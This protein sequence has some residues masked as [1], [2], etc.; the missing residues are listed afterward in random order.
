V[1]R[2]ITSWFIVC[3]SAFLLAS[4]VVG[5]LLLSLYRQST[6]EQ[7][8]RASA[9]VAHG[10]DAIAGRY[11][12]FLAGATRPPSDI[13]AAQFAQGLTSAVQIALRD[14]PGVEGGVWQAEQGSLA[15]AFPTYEGTGEKTDLPAAEEPHGGRQVRVDVRVLAATNRDLETAARD[16]RFRED[17]FYR[18]NVVPIHLP[19]L[20]ERLEDIVPLA[21]YFLRRATDPPKQLGAD[22]VECLRAHVWP[23]NVRELKNAI[24]RVA[25]LCRGNVITALDLVFL[26]NTAGGHDPNGPTDWTEGDLPAAVARLEMHMIKR[27]LQGAGGNRTEA[28]KQL[29][30]HRQLLYSKALKYGIDAGDVSAVHTA[31]VVKA[32]NGGSENSDKSK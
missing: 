16:G 13:R 32:D 6:T 9:A 18:L 17:L 10:C 29:G 7:L 21:E 31:T 25:I 26:S 20:R 5:L 1:P 23:G 11:Q 28:A 3:W 4:V 24:E 14:L 12:F 22:A 27:A 19:P 2:S 8:R 15:Y 30:I